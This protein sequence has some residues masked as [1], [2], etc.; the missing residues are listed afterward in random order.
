MSGEELRF[1]KAV[2]AGLSAPNFDRVSSYRD[3][4]SGLF[5]VNE[6]E[7]LSSLDSRSSG[8]ALGREP[9]LRSSDEEKLRLPPNKDSDVKRIP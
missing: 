8:A 7:L 3:V 5:V 2:R 6:S 9:E 4:D 1:R